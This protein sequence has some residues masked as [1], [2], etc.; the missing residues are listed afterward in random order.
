VA[1]GN[2]VTYTITVTNDGPSDAAGVTL[3][4]PPVAGLTITGANATIGSCTVAATTTC[5]IGLLNPQTSTIVTLI[6]RIDSA[7]AAGNL[8]NTA[9]AATTTPQSNTANDTA[10]ATVQ[11]TTS[12]DV[13]V[14][15]TGPGTIVGGTQAT[16]TLRASNAGP[17]QASGVV[18][19][20]V[21]PTGLTFVSGAG[22][23]AAGQTVTC[24]V[25]TLA[26]GASQQRSIVVSAAGTIG[27]TVVNTATVAATTADPNS[28][29]N[30][31]TFT[32]SSAG[33]ADVSITK[34]V[35]PTTPSP[36][37]RS[38]SRW[39][40]PTAVRPRRWVSPCPTTCRHR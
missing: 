18:L 28:G 9:T 19:Q 2:Q 36:A 22:C 16:Y 12:A 10:T 17:S 26:V 39:S 11:V 8:V 27:G 34:A 15:K 23:T 25:G 13:S 5:T 14:V 20:D 29:N 1:A 38:R 3:T 30:S 6:G 4:D 7:Q 33:V 35:S 21:L 24:T 40:S 37:R 31:S 32:S